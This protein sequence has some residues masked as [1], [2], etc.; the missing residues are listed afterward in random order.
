[1]RVVH[2]CTHT[3]SRGGAARASYRLHRVLSERGIFSTVL[4]FSSDTEDSSVHILGKSSVKQ[5]F[6]RKLGQKVESIVQAYARPGPQNVWTAGL[7]SPLA[8]DEHPEVLRADVVILYWVGGGFISLRRIGKLLRL[9]IPIVWR[10]SDMWPFTGGC[11]YSLGCDRYRQR[12]GLCP[13]LESR[14]DVDLSRLVWHYK[15]SSWDLASLTVVCPSNWMAGCARESSLFSGAD[16]RVIHT[17]VD[18]SMYRPR[19]RGA[20]RDLLGIPRDAKVVMAGADGLTFSDGRKGGQHLFDTLVQVQRALPEVLL[21]AF[22]TRQIPQGIRGVA[23]G[24]INDERLLAAAYCASDLFVS[25]SLEDN[26]PNTILEALACGLPVAAFG[27]EG[28]R[29]A[30]SGDTGVVVDPGDVEGLASGIVR[31]LRDDEARHRMGDR[32]REA[33]LMRFDL[34]RQGGLYADLVRGLHARRTNEHTVIP[35]R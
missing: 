29:D 22:G 26:L 23:L 33:A 27:I 11:H 31:C 21:A 24:A 35:N 16:V 5:R 4:A 2:L 25:T 13:Q 28:V 15:R 9:G 10:L 34:D 1:M 30:L 14:F 18:T 8:I 7:V 6:A 3:G 19:E 17:G 32:A 12:C 20:A